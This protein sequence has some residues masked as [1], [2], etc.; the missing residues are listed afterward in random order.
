M[1]HTW[2]NFSPTGQTSA[3][4]LAMRRYAD[5]LDRVGNKE[6][7]NHRVCFFRRTSRTKVFIHHE[8]DPRELGRV[9]PGDYTRDF[10]GEYST[11]RCEDDA[12]RN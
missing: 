9:Y 11:T 8:R 12:K 5:S 2:T 6:A 3:L 4:V 10:I 1:R 7:P